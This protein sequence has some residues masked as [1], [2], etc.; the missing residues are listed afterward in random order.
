MLMGRIEFSDGGNDRVSPR[1]C[2]L[3]AYVIVG[4]VP[5]RSRTKPV[6][7]GALLPKFQK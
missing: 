1:N 2:P 5:A 6:L 4:K 7:P 3:Q